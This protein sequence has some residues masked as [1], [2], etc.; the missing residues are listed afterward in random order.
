[1]KPQGFHT[2]GQAFRTGSKTF[3]RSTTGCGWPNRL[4]TNEREGE[5]S[6]N[7]LH[8]KRLRS[9]PF[10]T[11]GNEGLV[12]P[13]CLSSRELAHVLG[14]FAEIACATKG[15]FRFV[16]ESPRRLRDFRLLDK[17]SKHPPTHFRRA[18]TF[19]VASE[20]FPETSDAAPRSPTNVGALSTPSGAVPEPFDGPRS[21]RCSCEDQNIRRWPSTAL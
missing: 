20:A 1:M 14:V 2:G 18:E 19:A 16:G 8:R 11:Q 13:S 5:D 6:P 12:Q 4:P 21:L 9:K 10:A 15:A 7:A 17:F 3:Q